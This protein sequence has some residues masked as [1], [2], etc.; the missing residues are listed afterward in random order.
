MLHSKHRIKKGWDLPVI[1]YSQTL[2]LYGSL[3]QSFECRIIFRD[4]NNLAYV[5][6]LSGE[7]EGRGGGTGAS[8]RAGGECCVTCH[9]FTECHTF[10]CQQ[11]ISQERPDHIAV[12]LVNGSIRVSYNTGFDTATATIGSSLNDGQYHTLKLDVQKLKVIITVGGVKKDISTNSPGPAQFAG[13]PYMGGVKVFTPQMRDQLA[14]RENFVGCIKVCFPS[15]DQQGIEL[16]L[17]NQE[18][19]RK[20][21]LIR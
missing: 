3:F 6:W 13:R 10:N 7:G 21:G 9:T 14:T 1:L 11:D 8:A 19:G 17:L 4:M 2:I 15:F 12:E 5:A 18:G 20:V 16:T